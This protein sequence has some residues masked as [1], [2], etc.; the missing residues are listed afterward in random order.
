MG[1]C[2]RLV[3]AG[4]TFRIVS[5]MNIFGLSYQMSG[6]TGDA[7]TL[8]GNVTIQ[9]ENG[10]P[11]SPQAIPIVPSGVA[12]YISGASQQPLNGY[13]FVVTQGTLILVLTQQ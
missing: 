13:T 8:T 6:T 7:A 11:L 10:N 9:D 1:I 5:S 12:V 4:N 3:T 2:T